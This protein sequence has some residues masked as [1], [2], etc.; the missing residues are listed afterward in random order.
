MTEPYRSDGCQIAALHKSQRFKTQTR[1]T[2][3]RSAMRRCRYCIAESRTRCPW[4]SVKF[5]ALRRSDLDWC[6]RTRVWD[7]FLWLSWLDRADRSL[8]CHTPRI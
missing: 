3:G 1:N 7:G 5:I 4:P 2:S 6:L 8:V